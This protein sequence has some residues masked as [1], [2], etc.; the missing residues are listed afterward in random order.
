MQAL[1]QSYQEIMN[2]SDGSGKVAAL[3]AVGLSVECNSKQGWMV[4]DAAQAQTVLDG[5]SGSAAE[6]SFAQKQKIAALEAQ[7]E[8]VIAAG[9][10]Y[11][12]T[13]GADAAQHNY[14]IDEVPPFDEATGKPTRRDSQGTISTMGSWAGNVV[15]GVAGTAAWPANFVWRDADNA[16][17][18]MTA[19][20]CYAFTQD[21]ASY[22]AAMFGA[23]C[24]LY[25]RIMGAATAADVNAIDVTAGWPSN[26]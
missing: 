25:A 10:F 13:G 12:V 24:A 1:A 7:Y 8:S 6:L 21:V 3:E 11:S 14:Q 5:Y 15:N 9:R 4:S 17:V 20:Q 22:V 19:A 23:Y 16:L 18:P 2:G 26:P